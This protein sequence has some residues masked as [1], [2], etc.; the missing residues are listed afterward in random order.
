MKLLSLFRTLLTYMFRRSRIES[1]LEEELRSH[2]QSRAA[3]LERRGLSRPEAERQTRIEFG[4]YQRYRE[5]C[6]EA[7]GARLLEELIAD[8]HYGFRQ[9]RRSP[10]LTTIAVIT[11]AL[12]IAG[13]TA[14]FTA[15]NAVLLRP[16]A[17]RDPDR[18]VLISGGATEARFEEMRAAARLFTDI[19]AYTG[20]LETVTISG[21]T[22]PEALKGARVSANFLSILGI[23]PL[24]GRGFR[25]EEDARGG[26]SVAIISAELWRRR[27]GGDPSIV[28]R[29]AT[30]NATTYTVVGVLPPGFLFRSPM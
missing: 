30:M 1:E 17:Y 25:P 8:V 4:G 2:L 28:G 6:R 16:L 7:L 21:G 27:F 5:E 15:I 18:L 26:P 29:V 24:L 23:A 3:E 10:G 9:L 19:G 13:S 22:E 12:G 11:L 20:G 14:M